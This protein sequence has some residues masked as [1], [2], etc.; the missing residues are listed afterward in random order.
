MLDS[1][2]ETGAVCLRAPITI[3]QMMEK[4]A[5]CVTPDSVAFHFITDR[6]EKIQCCCSKEKMLWTLR[7]DLT[8]PCD[9]SRTLAGCEIIASSN[10]YHANFSQGVV[11][12]PAHHAHLFPREKNIGRANAIFPFLAMSTGILSKPLAEIADKPLSSVS[13]CSISSGSSRWQ[14]KTE[15]KP[16]SDSDGA[17]D[18][19]FPQSKDNSDSKKEREDEKTES[20]LESIWHVMHQPEMIPVFGF[21]IGVL[22]FI[23]IFLWVSYKKIYLSNNET[24]DDRYRS[25]LIEFEKDVNSLEGG[26]NID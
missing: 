2:D 4:V 17:M 26:K 1:S 8:K 24:L 18:N 22:L 5:D 14:T 12:T 19:T 23:A 16:L 7:G 21:L 25:S 10:T 15:D 11:I 13:R 3:K 6:G 9:V 20:F